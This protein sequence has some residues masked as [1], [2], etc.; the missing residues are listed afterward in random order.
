MFSTISESYIIGFL[1]QEVLKNNHIWKQSNGGEYF[2]KNINGID[3]DL[4]LKIRTTASICF[5]FRKETKEAWII[6]PETSIFRGKYRSEDEQ[7]LAQSMR[8]LYKSILSQHA[9]RR[10]KNFE[11]EEKVKQE[12]FNQFLFGTKD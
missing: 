6:E 1:L 12:L 5:R 3:I 4:V 11:D 7:A 10:L 2:L 8:Q 9:S